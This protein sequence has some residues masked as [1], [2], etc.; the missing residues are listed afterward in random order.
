MA[1][2]RKVKN[3]AGHLFRMAAFSLHHSL[4]PLGNYLRRMKAKLGPEA[5]TMAT[6]HKIAVIFCT[7]VKN[8]VEYDDTMWATR[9]AQREKGWKQNSNGKPNNW[10][11]NLF[12]SN[13]RLHSEPVQREGS[14]LE[15]SS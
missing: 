15:A 13:P 8:Q 5:S 2:S 10:A 1:G 11:T 12:P 6:A 3:R 9:D 14:S 4:T 7:I